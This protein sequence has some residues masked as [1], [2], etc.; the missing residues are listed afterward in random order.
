MLFSIPN[1]SHSR[2][3]LPIP[4]PKI[5]TFEKN[6][7][8]PVMLPITHSHSSHSRW[9]HCITA[10]GNDWRYPRAVLSLEQDLKI[11][12][13]LI[14]VLSHT[15]KPCNI[16]VTELL[17]NYEKTC[18]EVLFYCSGSHIAQYKKSYCFV[19]LSCFLYLILLHTCQRPMYC[20]CTA[21]VCTACRHLSVCGLTG[22]LGQSSP[23]AHGLAD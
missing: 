11:L 6:I 5:Y 21:N 22:V 12:F 17:R 20:I 13:C 18:S 15:C 23:R 8:I 4:I 1:P 14:E 19:V 2:K 3:V 9:R 10:R 7:P 16:A